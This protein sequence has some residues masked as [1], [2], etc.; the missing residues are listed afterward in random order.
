MSSIVKWEN[1]AFLDN[2][3]HESAYQGEATD[4]VDALWEELYNRK[5]PLDTAMGNANI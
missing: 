4:K 2:V 3:E 1:K 5:S